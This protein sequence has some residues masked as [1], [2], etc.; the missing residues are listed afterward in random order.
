M[1]DDT[2]RH[3]AL[4]CKA[5]GACFVAVTIPPNGLSLELM[6]TRLQKAVCPDCGAD[7]DQLL[8]IIGPRHAE[9][10]ARLRREAAAS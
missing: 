1:S 5:C 4:S 7:S 9:A 6:A 10:V 8:W 3:F 2:T